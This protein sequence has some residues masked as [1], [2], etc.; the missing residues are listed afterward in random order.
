MH[1]FG[2]QS[3]WYTNLGYPQ[4]TVMH[5]RAHTHNSQHSHDKYVSVVT[6]CND[7]EVKL[8]FPF[9]AKNYFYFFLK[10]VA[11][12]SKL[13]CLFQVSKLNINENTELC[14]KFGF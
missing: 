13:H 1:L 8:N 7:R 3:P 6:H 2:R 10:G 12:R 9:V 11:L 14:L 5:A 4:F